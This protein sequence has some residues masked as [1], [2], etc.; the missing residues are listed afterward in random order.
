M[1]IGYL[2]NMVNQF[3]NNPQQILEKWGIPKEYDSPES[4]TRYLMETGRVNQAQ[5]NQAN[6]LYK[7]FSK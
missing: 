6:Q 4:V 7:L 3:Q 5:I 2:M 1:N